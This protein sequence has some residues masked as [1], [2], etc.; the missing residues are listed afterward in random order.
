MTAPRSRPAE[1]SAHL[2]RLWVPARCCGNG[3]KTP[4]WAPVLEVREQIVPDVLRTL[5]MSGHASPA[6]PL[7]YRLPDRSRRP[8]IYRLWVGASAHGRAERVLVA[9][10]L[11]LAWEAARC[12]D[13]AWR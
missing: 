6:H 13:S 11:R 1:H 5:A 10:M 2:D 4:R 8:G 12:A 7:G 9:V 3:W